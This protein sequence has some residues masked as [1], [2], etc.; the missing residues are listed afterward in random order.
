MKILN[1]FTGIVSISIP[2]AVSAQNLPSLLKE[3]N[4]NATFSI[5]AFDASEQ[6]WGIAVATNN[7]YVGNSTIYIEPGVGAFSVI[8]E[9]EPKYALEGFQKLKSGK[10]IVQAI[11]ETKAKD[12]QAHYRQVSGIDAKGAVY[13]FTGAA[14]PYWKGKA[15]VVFGEGFIVMG[16]QL[17]DN[18]LTTMATT[19][20]T[21][22]GSLAERLL[23]SLAAGQAAGG[24]LSGKQS[25]AVVVKGTK[26]EWYN[27]IDL[28][29]DHSNTPVS[30]LQQLMDFHYG[31]IRLNQALY[32]LREG[33]REL[34]TTKLKEAEVMLEGWT[35]SYPRIVSAC[36]ILGE[37]DRAAQWIKRGLHENPNWSVYLPSFYMLKDHKELQSLIQPDTFD[38]TDWE[39]AISMLSNLGQ[40]QE[41]IKLGEELL[42]KEVRSSYLYFL[43]GR[44]YFYEKQHEKA[45]GCLD[46]AVLLDAENVEAQQ[47]LQQLKQ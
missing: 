16:N 40:E 20:E 22:K 32:A 45:M 11:R 34:G 33:N 36:L 19:F 1:F 2:F 9:T 7:I 35:G 4:I 12:P 3:K 15:G 26:N 43:L 29:V 18:V 17:G 10:T 5:T 44:S 28:R 21:A 27:Q 31:R 39:S 38:T 25:A 6:E 37:H 8:A 47:L 24:Q 46:A 42:K 41:A 14:L 23:K 30:D 13:A